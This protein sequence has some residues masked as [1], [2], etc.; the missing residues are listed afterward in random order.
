MTKLAGL[1]HLHFDEV[2]AG[3]TTSMVV[4]A[5]SQAHGPVVLKVPYPD[6]ENQFESD[7]LREYGGDGAISLLEFD[8]SSRALLLERAIPGSPLSE[9]SDLSR[10]L[11]V[12]CLILVRLRRTL[13]SPPDIPRCSEFLD[14]WLERASSAIASSPTASRAPLARGVEVGRRLTAGDGPDLLVNRDAHLGNF[15]RSE[16]SGWLLIDPKPMLGEA[17]FEGG[18]LLLDLM[19]RTSAPGLRETATLLH[20]VATGLG[21]AEDRTLAWALMRALENADW[22]RSVGEDPET[23]ESRAVLLARLS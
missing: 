22:A 8:P 4:A 14:G 21:V 3:G 16:R 1:W 5:R 11:E 17:A 2:L 12:A 20:G 19:A 15:L 18:F 7:A 9:M 6:S 13:R 10:A 23:W